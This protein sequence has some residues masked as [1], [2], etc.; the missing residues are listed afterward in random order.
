MGVMGYWGG[1]EGGGGKEGGE[2]G[3]SVQPKRIAAPKQKQ[4]SS[5]VG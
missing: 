5:E 2:S 1:G 4:I 3:W